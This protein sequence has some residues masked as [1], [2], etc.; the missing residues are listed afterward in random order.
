MNVQPTNDQVDQLF[1]RY[2]RTGSPGCAL[3]VMKDGETVY[4][5]GYGLAHV[6]LGVLNLPSTVFNIG[7]MAK[8]FTA[9]ALALL[10]DEGKLSLDDDM[11][12]HLP[13]MPA[14]G[15][16][17]TLRHLV[18]HTS[19]L[20]GS[21]PEL[22][23]LAEWRDTDATTTKDV[24]HLLEAQRDLNYSPGD[25]YLYVNSNYVLLAQICERVS[26][27]SFA[28]F[29]RE[30]IFEPLGMSR[31]VVND[32]YFRLIPGRANG[33]YED[34]DVW[35]NAPLTDSVVGPTNIY[36]TVEDLAK[37]DENFYAG[38]VGGPMV[39]EQM[40]QPGRLNDGTLLD[41]AFGL[42]LG[43]AH[44][45]RGWQIVEHGGSQGGYSSWMVRFPELHLGV[46]ILFN[47][48]IWNMRE[49][50]LQVADLFLQDNPAG[51]PPGEEAPVQSAT[52][53][54]L[55]F[56]QLDG[57]AGTYFDARR[58]ALRKVTCEQGQ[59]R[60]EGFALLPLTETR[61]AFE[62]EPETHVAFGLAGDG[63]AEY[64]KTITSSGE[65]RYDRVEA[66]APTA[67]EL[68][69][70]TGRYYSPEL[71]L[72]WTI[73]AGDDHLVA[74]RRKYVD[75]TLSPVFADA[76]RDDWTPLMGY[77]T[78]YLVVFE[79]NAQRNIAGLR[80]SGTRV[81]NLRFVKC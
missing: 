9:F 51:P 3:A 53:I 48:F 47:H 64:V 34:E 18:H 30:R 37:W 77:P 4:R 6:E 13:E 17:I 35:F 41:Y 26:G 62:V 76:F 59:L 61:F 16:A 79:R 46:V 12:S 63:S 43:P 74:Q 7:S 19:G 22:L 14:F 33:Y 54:E 49:Y 66:R 78:T 25:E 58:A 38:A 56:A 32:S 75:S 20:R 39:I 28:T 80:V 1:V 27:Q 2:T 72:Y 71:D 42:Q 40:H 68:A 81:R 21:F 73:A 29:C 31:T 60:F 52:P 15:Q 70:Y 50:A 69:E 45:H 24:V 57:K 10:A 55:G 11:R 23:A 8:Q 65:Y 36:S 67:E 44:R 5:Q